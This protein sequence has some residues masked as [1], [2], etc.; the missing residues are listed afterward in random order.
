MY[1]ANHCP[2]SQFLAWT[3]RHVY[4]MLGISAI[5]TALHVLAG[6][7]WLALPWVPIALIGL[8]AVDL[9]TGAVGD[10]LPLYRG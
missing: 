6:W 1:T 3:R 4:W 10:L 7:H 8:V 5:P 9:R 2:L